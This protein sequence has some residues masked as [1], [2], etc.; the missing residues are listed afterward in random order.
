MS[1][2][3]NHRMR[4]SKVADLTLTGR[5][6]PLSNLSTGNERVSIITFIILFS[7][8]LCNYEKVSFG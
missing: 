7:G 6:N 5:N 2:K 4:D 8:W 1:G 3:G